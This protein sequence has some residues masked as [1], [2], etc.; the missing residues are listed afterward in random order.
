[1]AELEYGKRVI[2]YGPKGNKNLLT[3]KEGGR[4]STQNGFMEHADIIKAGDGAEIKTNKGVSYYCF[5]PTYMDYIMNF[6]RKAQIIYPKDSAMILMW[7]DV[8]PGLD[9][10]ESGLGQGALSI[11]ILRALAGKGNLTTYELRDDFIEQ[12]TD[13]IKDFA[14]EQENHKVIKDNI[15]EGFEG[16]Y[17]RIFLDLPEPWHV[18]KHAKEGL[19]NGGIMIAY[20]PTIL[21]VKEY[22]DNLRDCGFF[23][24]IET[25]EFNKRPWK[26]EGLSVRPEMWIYNHSAFIVSARKINKIEKS[27][28]LMNDKEICENI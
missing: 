27:D 19:K 12:A 17:D 9:I 28:D 3:L 8:Y 6:K 26:V 13:I 22:V 4:F 20:I 1:M 5:K 14:G 21:Q 2:L 24:E 25:H 15:Y 11:A 7:G 16:V 23:I 10:L 18:I